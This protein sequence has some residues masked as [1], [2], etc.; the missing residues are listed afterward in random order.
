MSEKNKRKIKAVLFDFDGTLM[1]TNDI[2][3]QSWHYTY[4]SVGA[5]APDDSQI[6][7][8]FGEPLEDTMVK[9]FPDRDPR[10]MVTIYRRYQNEIFKGKVNI[11]PRVDQMVMDLKAAGFRV[12]IVTS[13]LW[14][15]LTPAVYDFP[16]ADEFD[17][18][19]SATDTK[20]HKPDPTCLLLACEKLGIAPE[21]AIYVGDSRFDVHCAKNA[22]M[23][24][25]LVDWTICLPPEKRT[26]QYLP[27]FVISK[28]E[29]LIDIVS[30]IN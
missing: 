20:A 19:I 22:G 16:F 8:T 9:E 6:A 27:D 10:E 11:F 18:I 5:A 29:E 25:V 24:S 3:L 15:L 30:N 26:G 28:P 1:N 14:S 21:E 23:K 13:R 17:T 7:W 12:A 4:D 2:I